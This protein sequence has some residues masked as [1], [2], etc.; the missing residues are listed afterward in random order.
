MFSSNYIEVDKFFAGP[1]PNNYNEMRGRTSSPNIQVSRNS[2][3]SSTKS[4]VAYHEKIE[5]NNTI[6]EDIDMNDVSPELL[7]ET[8]QEKTSWVSKAANTNNNAAPTNLQYGSHKYPNISPVHVNDT[9]INISL[10]YDPNA[11]TE[12]DL[13]DGSFH[14]I[15]LHRSIEHLALNTKNIRDLLNFMTKY[16]LNKQVNPVRSNDL[17]NLKGIG[18]AV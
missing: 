16:I 17:D 4:L 5:C 2:L 13:W 9:V 10:P 8:I 14:P 18:E 3:V 7:Y 1:S 11:P 12:P 15:S 6:I